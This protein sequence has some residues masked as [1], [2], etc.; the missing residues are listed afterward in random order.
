M[1]Y[2]NRATLFFTLSLAVSLLFAIFLDPKSERFS[3]ASKDSA[4]LV[5]DDLKYYNIKEDRV[6]L[7]IE[8]KRA[9]RFL[10]KDVAEEIKIFRD[11]SQKEEASASTLVYKNSNLYLNGEAKYSREDGLKAQFENGVYD[12]KNSKFFTN[13][14]FTISSKEYIARG[15]YMIFDRKNS[16]VE[17]KNIDIKYRF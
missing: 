9:Y 3:Y 13:S 10:D 6:E 12:T 17:I 5:L 16:E 15:D 7:V 14:K 1:R 8:A 11:S 2:G 4:I